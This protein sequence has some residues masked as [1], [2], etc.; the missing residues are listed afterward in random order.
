MFGS[1][2]D[3]D[4]GERNLSGHVELSELEKGIVFPAVASQACK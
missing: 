4:K 2:A 1:F 3:G